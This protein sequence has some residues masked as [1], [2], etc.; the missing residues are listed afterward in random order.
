MVPDVVFHIRVSVVV[1]RRHAAEDRELLHSLMVSEAVGAGSMV[2]VGVEDADVVVAGDED[3]VDIARE[4]DADDAT[5]LD[6]EDAA[7][8]D[9]CFFARAT[10]SSDTL[11]WEREASAEDVSAVSIAETEG[12]FCK[13][14][15]G[16]SSFC[17]IST[18]GVVPRWR[19]SGAS[20]GNTGI[21]DSASALSGSGCSFLRI[22]G[23]GESE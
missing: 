5:V 4:A 23:T 1:A 20:A 13:A 9:A 16:G 21:C 10:S 12:L 18:L 19:F 14:G 8:S 6:E 22:L 3:V 17:K 2:T 11:P 7:E 15:V